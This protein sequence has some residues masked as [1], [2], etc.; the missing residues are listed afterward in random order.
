[1]NWEF[2]IVAV[3]LAVSFQAWRPT[4]G[5]DFVQDLFSLALLGLPFFLLAGAVL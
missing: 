1:M 2:V 3:L 5:G 4:S